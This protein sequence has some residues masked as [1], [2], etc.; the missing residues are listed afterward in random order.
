MWNTFKYTVLDLLRMPGV[1]VWAL[2]F[3]L[4]L[5]TVFMMMFGPIDEMGNQLDPIP[6]AVV[7]SGETA[8][9]QA[10]D[11]FLQ[12]MSKDEDG[13]DTLFAITT[14]ASPTEAMQLIEDTANGENPCVGYIEL[15]DGEPEVHVVGAASTGGVEKI[16]SSILV[17]AMDT[18]VANSA[19]IK[20]L[21]A[22]DPMMLAGPAGARIM[23]TML[24]PLQATV[25]TTVTP[26]QPKESVRFYFALLGMA[27]LFGGSLGLVAL[28]RMKPNTSALGARR[29]VGATPHGRAVAATILGSW[30]ITFA[31]LFITYLYIRYVANVSFGDHDFE[32]LL[33]AAFAALTATAL[34]SAISAIPHVPESG[35]SGILTGVVCFASLFAGLYGQPTMELADMIARDFPVVELVNPAAQIAQAFYSVMY[36]DTLLPLMEHLGI[37]LVMAL[38]LFALSA[39]SL[40]RRRYASL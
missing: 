2:G 31:C 29:A 34:G 18:Y 5:S 40:K 4:I 38:I 19:M 6:V 14:V 30:I 21:V 10:F 27:A 36:Y 28:Q 26:N 22:E 37:L 24:E 15:V 3:P 33:V 20:E 7:Q 9:D 16:N 35:K 39:R 32:C 25:Q 12:A 13:Q 1:L 23:D 17:M 8:D 11:A